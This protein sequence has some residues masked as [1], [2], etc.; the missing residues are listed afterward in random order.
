LTAYANITPEEL[1]WLGERVGILEGL[2][3]NA[4]EARLA[5]LRSE[6]G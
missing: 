5:A 6:V 4:C 1:V 2:V 3:R